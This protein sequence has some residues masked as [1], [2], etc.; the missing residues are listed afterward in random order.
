[1]IIIKESRNQ[2]GEHGV[3]NEEIQ[4]KFIKYNKA[5]PEKSSRDTSLP[6]KRY[7]KK[8]KNKDP[9][10]EL[11]LKKNVITTSDWEILSKRWMKSRQLLG[12]TSSSLNLLDGDKEMLFLRGKKQASRVIRLVLL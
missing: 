6:K 9:K 4:K 2:R 7:K 11:K 1:M 5:Q 3:V 8:N 12:V 10:E